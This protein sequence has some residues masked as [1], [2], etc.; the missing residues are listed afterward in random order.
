MR[1]GYTSRN[2]RGRTIVQASVDVPDEKAAV[3]AAFKALS[4]EVA[5]QDRERALLTK[6]RR[7]AYRRKRKPDDA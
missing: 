1:I 6:G 2:K 7:Q 4:E 5:R 3:K